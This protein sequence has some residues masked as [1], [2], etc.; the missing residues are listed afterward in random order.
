[1]VREHGLG[2]CCTWDAA[3]EEG[4]Q[5]ASSSDS[6][7]GASP[8][9]GAS[10]GDAE[11]APF[12]TWKFRPDGV[13]QRT[14]DFIWCAACMHACMRVLQYLVRMG[15]ACRHGAVLDDDCVYACTYAACAWAAHAQSV[16]GCVRAA[17]QG[18]GIAATAGIGNHSAHCTSLC[19][20]ATLRVV[21]HRFSRDPRLRLLRRWRMPGEAE[22][23]PRGLPCERYPSDHLALCAVFGLLPDA[24]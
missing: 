16:T 11:R 5:A 2:L 18:Q 19:L 4:G 1:M 9:Q 7:N 13:S 24:D 12:T 6:G 22:I 15:C 23:G 20:N 3:R 8:A 10:M 14:I 17:T 21:P